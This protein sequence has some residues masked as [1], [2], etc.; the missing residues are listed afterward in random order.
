MNQLN[1]YAKTPT[2][3]AQDKAERSSIAFVQVQKT[4][5]AADEGSGPAYA[6][7]DACFAGE[8]TSPANGSEEDRASDLA[9]D[10]APIIITRPEEKDQ[11]T[12]SL[13]SLGSSCTDQLRRHHDEFK[14]E[15]LP[16]HQLVRDGAAARTG[17]GQ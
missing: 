13:C 5:R 7:R 9:H 2:I 16:R 17:S 12:L 15:R 1:P 6:H 4:C 3:P 8:L 14:D 10:D 11:C